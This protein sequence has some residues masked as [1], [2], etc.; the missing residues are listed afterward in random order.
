MGKSGT[1]EKRLVKGWK[2]WGSPFAPKHHEA[3]NQAAEILTFAPAMA[4]PQ[5]MARA[6]CESQSYKS[7]SFD[8]SCKSFRW[9][10]ALLYFF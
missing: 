4:I 5:N 6:K 2:I 9:Q 3:P 10:K 8:S 7:D 1:N